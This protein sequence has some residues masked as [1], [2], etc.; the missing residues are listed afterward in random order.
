MYKLIPTEDRN[1]YRCCVCDTT[2]SVKYL[3]P[4]YNPLEGEETQDLPYCNRCA[5]L[6]SVLAEKNNQ[7]K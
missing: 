5:L 6:H 3:I 4:T 2:K 7:A 1:K